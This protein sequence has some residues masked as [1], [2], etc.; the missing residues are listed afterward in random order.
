ME[1]PVS[2]P[3]ILS[4]LQ[5]MGKAENG[6]QGMMAH[7]ALMPESG[8]PL[9]LHK[10]RLVSGP[11]PSY[12]TLCDVDRL[13]QTITHAMAG[14]LKNGRHRSWKIA[15]AA[16]HGN[17]CGGAYSEFS[18]RATQFAITGDLRAV[19]GGVVMVN[20]VIDEA[21]ATDLLRHE[22][23]SGRRLLAAVAA[24]SF[25]DE[26]VRLLKGTTD[27]CVLLSNPALAVIDGSSLDTHKRLR[28]VRGGFIEQ[29]NY[30]FV[31]HLLGAE[32]VG[33]L[34]DE[35]RLTDI[36]FAWAIGSTSNS[37]TITLV[38]NGMLIGNGVG[39]QDRVGAA[40]L[41]IKRAHDA[42]HAVRGAVAYSDSFFP[43][44]DGPLRLI[45]AGVHAIF[46][47]SGSIRD[48][49]VKDVCIAHDTSLIM[50]SD[51]EARGFFGH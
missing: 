42:G 51:G 4:D 10:F 33:P 39:Q 9:A 16:K 2:H 30:T 41:A 43:F 8:D 19:F 23:K 20:Y 5:R 31:P 11:A 13:L 28:Y 48:Q 49:E 3:H 32:C 47:T 44:P 12:N 37:N 29:E 34:P 17:C 27:K 50:L 45:Q 38:S 22:M 15:L 26:A 7:Y 35:S 1:G 40:E 21:V 25:T 36:A 6:E 14:L 24:P 46:S 18:A